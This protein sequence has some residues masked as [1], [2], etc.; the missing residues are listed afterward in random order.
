M[1]PGL[2]PSSDQ[3]RETFRPAPEVVAPRPE[4]KPV[5]LIAAPEVARS[6][7]ASYEQAVPGSLVET[8]RL[9]FAEADSRPLQTLEGRGAE[10]AQLVCPSKPEV[11]RDFEKFIRDRQYQSGAV[12]H[13]RTELASTEPHITEFDM[14]AVARQ[15]NRTMDAAF[16]AFRQKIP[17]E[18]INQLAYAARDMFSWGLPELATERFVTL[19]EHPELQADLGGDKVLAREAKM[20]GCLVG[21][22]PYLSTR[23]TGQVLS[24]LSRMG[25]ARTKDQW[26]SAVQTIRAASHRADHQQLLDSS[27]FKNAQQQSNLT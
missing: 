27:E 23:T 18:Y 22:V 15:W 20:L 11:Y 9:M 4:I 3:A 2:R 12:K 14:D 25:T 8:I 17:P 13:I 16:Q 7:V 1:I 19:C 26:R 24:D 10:Y 6:F 5:A 21:E